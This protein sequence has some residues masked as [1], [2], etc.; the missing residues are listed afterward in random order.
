MWE[1]TVSQGAYNSYERLTYFVLYV[2]LRGIEGVGSDSGESR[3]A[4]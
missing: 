4:S 2:G 1:T 3:E